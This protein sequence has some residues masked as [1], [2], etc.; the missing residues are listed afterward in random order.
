M[1][2]GGAVEVPV[3]YYDETTATVAFYVS[4]DSGQTWSVAA[5][6][7]GSAVYAP[8]A[9]DANHFIAGVDGTLYESADAGASWHA[10]QSNV[11]VV[12]LM[13]ATFRSPRV[14]WAQL[15]IPECNSNKQCIVND[16]LV[17][18]KD[19]GSTWTEY[20]LT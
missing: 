12:H 4:R 18:T 14:G 11:P 15:T 19:G 10:I 5:P 3:T 16:Y 1:A 20:P 17:T 13:A 9:I 6:L 8:T 7:S 2:A